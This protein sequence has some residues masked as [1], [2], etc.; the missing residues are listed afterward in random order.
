MNDPT[1]AAEIG[2][3][4]ALADQNWIII[5]HL[6]R[7]DKAIISYCVN[8]ACM[9]DSGKKHERVKFFL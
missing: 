7:M 2:L 9:A 6:A 8:K 1:G 5:N 3:L 4:Q